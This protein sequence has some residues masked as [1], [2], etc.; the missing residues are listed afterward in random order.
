MQTRVKEIMT[1]N[2]EMI[3]PTASLME[4]AEKM[5]QEEC[6]V[7]P[8]GSKGDLRGI[9]TDR[10]IVIR[11]VSKGVDVAGTEVA[12]YM[13]PSVQFCRADDSIEEAVE[14]MRKHQ[15]SRL[16][17]LDADE[18]PCG[19]LTFGC[20]MRE[21]KNKREISNVIECAFGKKVA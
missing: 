20:I 4:A 16:V 8:V 10:D 1:Y 17:V 5:K 13:T 18:E 3:H 19:I 14:Q 15:V 21:D 2:P 12:D 7:L 6:G 9:I 11:A